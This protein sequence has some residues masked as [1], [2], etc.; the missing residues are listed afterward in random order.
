[1][2]WLFDIEEDGHLSAQKIEIVS[3]IRDYAQPIFG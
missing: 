1:M 2:K 3:G